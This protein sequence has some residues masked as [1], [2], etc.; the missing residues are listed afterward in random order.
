MNNDC[1]FRFSCFAKVGEDASFEL[2]EN[3]QIVR[4]PAGSVVSR[5]G[6]EHGNCMFFV[7]CSVH[8]QMIAKNGCEIVL[9]R[10]SGMQTCVMTTA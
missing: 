5:P 3:V 7:D 8:V 6:S 9:Y 4:L 2:A 1:I 10:V